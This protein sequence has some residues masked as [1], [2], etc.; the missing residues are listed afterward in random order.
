MPNLRLLPIALT[1]MT[2]LPTSL[3]AAEGSTSS[4]GGVR[5]ENF[6]DELVAGDLAFPG[7]ERID[8]PHGRGRRTLIRAREHFIPEM[9]RS[10]ENL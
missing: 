8:V 3:A 7:G 4:D 6:E 10:V 2:L 5:V 1:L 9:M